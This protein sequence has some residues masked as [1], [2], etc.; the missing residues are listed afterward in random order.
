MNK[1]WANLLICL[2]LEKQQKKLEAKGIMVDISQLRMEWEAARNG[3][4]GGN[5]EHFDETTS[6]K[7]MLI[8]FIHSSLKIASFIGMTKMTPSEAAALNKTIGE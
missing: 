2:Q 3:G 1:F 8:N 4:K 7:Q 6:N 5:N